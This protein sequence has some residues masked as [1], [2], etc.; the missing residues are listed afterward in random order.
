MAD[1]DPDAYLAQDFDP[2]AYL[3]TQE[4][5]AAPEPI[6]SMTMW[7]EHIRPYV[8]PAAEIGGIMMGG[9]VGAP[10]GLGGAVGGAGLGYGIAKTGLRIADEYLGTPDPR[11]P[12]ERLLSSVADVALGGT[13]EAAGPVVGRVVGKVVGK[14]ID[15]FSAA[16]TR[17]TNILR[18]SVEDVAGTVNALRRGSPDVT[19]AKVVAEVADEP[20]FQ[21]LS[22]RRLRGEPEALRYVRKQAKGERQQ[23][24][25]TLEQLAKGSTATDVRV[26]EKTAKNALN[27]RLVP[28][29]ETELRIATQASRAGVGLEAKVVRAT[30]AATEAGDKVRRLEYLKGVATKAAKRTSPASGL[31]NVPRYT[32][33]GEL[34]VKAEKW[35]SD[36]A[37]ASLDLGQGRTFAKVALDVMESYGLKPLRTDALIQTIRQ[38]RTPGTAG[39]DLIEGALRQIADD[40]AEWTG[41]GGIIDAAA[42]DAIRKNSVNAVIARLRPGISQKQANNHA[43]QVVMDI[44]PVLVRAIEDAGGVGYGKYLADY[45]AG[46]KEIAKTKL[47][48][49]ALELFKNTPEQFIKLV[50]GNSPQVVEKVLGP[51]SYN[52]AKEVSAGEIASLREVAS[53][54]IRDAAMKEQAT[55]GAKALEEL[56]QQ[57]VGK[58]YLP[59]WLNRFVVTAKLGMEV[60]EQR[61]GTKTM[62]L[63]TEALKTPQGTADLMGALPAAE[64]SRILKIL[65]NPTTWSPA[66][67]PVI[68][69]AAAGVT[70]NLS[71]NP[72][73][74][75]SLTY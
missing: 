5:L 52:I 31:P 70:N 13:F 73:N 19:A 23:S 39:N 38:L 59:T 14:G 53:T 67:Q 60:L 27:D 68:S 66:V 58:T 8:A 62:R 11:G 10:L 40:L 42:L 48:G 57:N 74:E 64:R 24:L 7:E 35:S 63:L 65:T 21:A 25:N 1:F 18:S 28:V 37:T 44:K 16:K 49:K 56:L 46:M 36:A 72:V 6:D 30:E 4:P 3:G 71:Q 54:V 61:I 50:E 32:Y 43:A 34:A 17:A 26:V 33:A 75:N 29:L 15:L 69:G 22:K 55:A 47:F 2:D 20:T 51:G 12:G 9:V 41:K 45:A